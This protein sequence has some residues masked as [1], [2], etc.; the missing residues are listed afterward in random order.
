MNRTG[1]DV[2][3]VGAGIVGAACAYELTNAG[4]RVTVIEEHEIAGGAT[5]A[6]MGH[7]VVLDEPEAQFALTRYSLELWREVAAFLPSECDYWE[8]GTVWVAAD[9]EEMNV[10]RG[11]CKYYSMHGVA[12]ELLDE[13]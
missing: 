9:E 12:V 2:V 5:N 6:G 11:Q 4:L 13:K 10:A 3:I 8:C 7:L 1:C